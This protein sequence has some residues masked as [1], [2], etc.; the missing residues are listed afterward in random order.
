MI[1]RIWIDADGCPVVAQTI[2]IAKKAAIP[3]TVV[4][5]Y[6]IEL[7]SEYAEIVT[8]DISRDAADY[9]IA[10][11]IS[12]DDIVVTQ[13]NGLAAMVLAKEGRCINVNGRE[14]N[15]LNIDFI[16]DSRHHGRVARM[17]N[18]RGPRHKKRSTQD[19]QDFERGLEALILANK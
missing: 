3:V 18:Q 4:K 6:A 10:N 13:D 8:V 19:D 14:I 17:Q 2:K 9:Y 16:L 12:K 11:H 1:M 5:N 15:P 7:S